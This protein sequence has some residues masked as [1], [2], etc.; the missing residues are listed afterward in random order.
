[1]VRRNADRAFGVLGQP[2]DLGREPV[3]TGIVAECA[4]V[5]RARGRREKK[6]EGQGSREGRRAGA[7]AGGVRAGTRMGGGGTGSPGAGGCRDGHG[8][9]LGWGGGGGD[10]VTLGRGGAGTPEQRPFANVWLSR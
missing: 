10:M 5:L 3:Q 7:G 6:Q 1:M 8:V 9:L 4:G 2:R